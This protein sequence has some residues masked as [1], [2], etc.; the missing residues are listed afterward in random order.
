M[1]IRRP[2][3]C[4]GKGGRGGELRVTDQSEGLE[5]TQAQPGVCLGWSQKERAWG[6]MARLRLAKICP[7]VPTP[8]PTPELL[9]E[10]G[11]LNPGLSMSQMP[12]SAGP[13]CTGARPRGSPSNALTHQIPSLA[14]PPSPSSALPLQRHPLPSPEAGAHPPQG[15]HFRSTHWHSHRGVTL[16]GRQRNGR[17]HRQGSSFSGGGGQGRGAGETVP[18]PAF[19]GS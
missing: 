18:F 17:S 12:R 15:P 19:S 7:A 5:L 10:E 8:T 14:S 2:A 3:P 11:G 6:F 16:W 4:P 13:H 1:G 9:C